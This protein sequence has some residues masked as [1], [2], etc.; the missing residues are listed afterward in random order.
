[1][2]N[3]ILQTQFDITIIGGGLAGCTAAFHLHRLGFRVL[4]LEGKTYPCDKLCGE[5]LSP[6]SIRSFEAMDV[7]GKIEALGP[8]LIDH[9]LI[10]TPAGNR[11]HGEM[12]GNAIGL[13]RYRLDWTIWNHCSSIGVE[14]IDGF[15]VNRIDG[16]LPRGF[17]VSG[18]YKDGS[19]ASFDTRMVIGAF[20][21]RSNLDRVLNRRFWEAD[22]GYVA[23]KAHFEG[24]DLGR[25]VELHSFRGGYCGLCHVESNIPIH[26][27]PDPSPK[28]KDELSPFPFREGDRGVRSK[29]TN[30]CLIATESVFRSLG[31]SRERL[32]DEVLSTNPVLQDRL[33]G[34][35]RVS[36]EFLS[37]S[38]I[39]F[40][41]KTCWEG[42]ILMIGDSAGMITPLCGDGM[43]M[44]MRSA[45]LCTPLVADY[46]HGNISVS[47]LKERY[48]GNWKSEFD[49]RLRWGRLLQYIL[50]QPFLA[51]GS[52]AL[53]S[54]FPRLGEFLISQ[55]RD[56]DR[57][58]FEENTASHL[59]EKD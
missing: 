56:T 33:K 48:L 36:P 4:L 20:G 3:N 46:L 26:D 32:F 51:S 21:K 16:D 13:S 31:S 30:L 10:T 44:G 47:L 15:K 52:V 55:T 50:F 12:P 42:D 19:P 18:V 28:Q 9:V 45:E 43:A 57:I 22:H 24:I 38:Q 6:E 1:M 27:F 11:Y 5:V 8:A 49:S 53:I 58:G 29:K 35:C 17:S 14:A 39:A 41:P 7:W 59:K 37:I 25:R 2:P 34:M 54:R 23:F 40:E